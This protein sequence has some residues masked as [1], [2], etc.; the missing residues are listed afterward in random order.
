MENIFIRE[1]LDRS[2]EEFYKW[3]HVSIA[4]FFKEEIRSETAEKEVIDA[5]LHSA[6]CL[7]T[8]FYKESNPVENMKVFRMNQM[9]MPF[10]FLCRHTLELLIK[11]VLYS[12]QGEK[13]KKTHKLQE[14][15]DELKNNFEINNEEFDMLINA[16]NTID[17]DG[18]K[19]RYAN[20][21]KGNN[22]NK[23][24]RFVRSDLILG[25]TKKIY[26]EL[27]PETNMS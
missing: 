14:L 19:L 27:I 8:C 21:G 12:K 16:L 15:W 22:Y 4:P 1:K 11:A 26:E 13:I 10:L 5:Y 18:C 9:C 25:T 17:D 3:D 7:Y 6:E 20:D 2:T 24:P 23:H